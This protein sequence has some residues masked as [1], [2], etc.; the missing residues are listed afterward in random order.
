MP[1]LPW[2]QR[3]DIDIDRDYVVMASRLPLKTYRHTC[4]VWSRQA[5]C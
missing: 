3:Q 1:A 5:M 4:G 2:V